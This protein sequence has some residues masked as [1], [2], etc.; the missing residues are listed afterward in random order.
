MANLSR[1]KKDLPLT[2]YAVSLQNTNTPIF[3]HE[4]INIVGKLNIVVSAWNLYPIPAGRLA[5]I[6]IKTDGIWKIRY[7]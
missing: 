3:Y 7:L 4:F 1:A 2:W 5:D 6:R